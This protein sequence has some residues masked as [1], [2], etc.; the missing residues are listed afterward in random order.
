MSSTFSLDFVSSA[1]VGSS[2]TVFDGIA[3]FRFGGSSLQRMPRQT[4]RLH[5]VIGSEHQDTVVCRQN[6]QNRKIARAVYHNYPPWRVPIYRRDY[7]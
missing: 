1:P 4:D 7:T 5:Q 6:R 3:Y 2:R